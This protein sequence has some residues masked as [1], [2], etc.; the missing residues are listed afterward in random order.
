VD[1]HKDDVNTCLKIGSIG[2]WLTLAIFATLM[3]GA[4]LVLK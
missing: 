3:L 2:M 1:D 4:W